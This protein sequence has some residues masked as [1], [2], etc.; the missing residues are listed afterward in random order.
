MKNVPPS[1]LTGKD[2]KGCEISS[3]KL[4]FDTLHGFFV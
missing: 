1:L 4:S 2:W 3:R